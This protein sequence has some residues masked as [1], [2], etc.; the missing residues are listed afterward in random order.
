MVL[1][2]AVSAIGEAPARQELPR[3]SMHL[4]F[5]LNRATQQMREAFETELRPLGIKSR[6]YGVLRVVSEAGPM[7]QHIIGSLLHCDRNMMVSVVDDLERLGLARRDVNPQDRRAYAIGLT[8]AGRRL[9]EKAN[10]L[11]LKVE[12]D[13]LAPLS[14]RQRRQLQELLNILAAPSESR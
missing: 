14:P 12:Q 2:N 8:P 5:V 7:P 6:H 4:G 9:L 11:A 1:R 10:A 3:M 13:F